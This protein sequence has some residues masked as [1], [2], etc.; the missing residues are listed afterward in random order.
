MMQQRGPIT[1]RKTRGFTLVEIMV[2]IVILGLLAGLV[3][4]NV[5]GHLAKA[6]ITRAKADIQTL[7]QAILH[8]KMDTGQYPDNQAG[9]LA[10]VEQPPGDIK[11]WNK[12]GYLQTKEVPQDPWNND[13]NYQIPGEYA[14]FDIWSW[15][16]DGQEGGEDEDADIYNSTIERVSE[17]PDYA[18]KKK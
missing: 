5:I 18:P 8:Y 2:V 1:P 14:K 17:N 16:A 13:Y 7:E 12:D 15:G 3:A 4:N 11:G 9:L 10:L 6:R